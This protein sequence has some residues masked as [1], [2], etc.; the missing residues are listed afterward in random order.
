MESPRQRSIA[1]EIRG[2]KKKT[3][4]KIGNNDNENNDNENNEN[5]DDNNMENESNLGLLLFYLQ[6]VKKK[7]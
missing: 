6:K 3:K 4:E 1:I 2:I 5:D 7:V